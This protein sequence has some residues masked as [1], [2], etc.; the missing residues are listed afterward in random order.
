DFILSLVGP[1][2]REAAERAAFLRHLRH[3]FS[4]W[5]DGR[6][7]P[8]AARS[9]AGPAS[10]TFVLLAAVAAA[11]LQYSRRWIVSPVDD[12]VRVA[13]AGFRCA[14]P[15]LI[16]R[17]KTGTKSQT[18]RIQGTPIDHRNQLNTIHIT[19]KPKRNGKDPYKNSPFK[20]E[21]S[22]LV[23]NGFTT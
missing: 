12:R 22:V 14:F 20:E 18:A 2:S 8:Q 3:Q 5:R 6:H 1:V 17:H 4:C 11:E 19:Q 9:G 16:V 21:R 10:R 13:H 15:D 7:H 23:V